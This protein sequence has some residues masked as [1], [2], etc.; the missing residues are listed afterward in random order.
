MSDI[1]G[2]VSF[3]FWGGVEGSICCFCIFLIQLY[4]TV[5]RVYW[6]FCI[7]H[8]KLFF[9]VMWT[10]GTLLLLL[11]FVISYV[12]VSEKRN[13]ISKIEISVCCLQMN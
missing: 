12:V 8:I 9:Y 3:F 6:L 1:F 4:Y 13:K 11:L 5:L 10:A 2:G 7:D